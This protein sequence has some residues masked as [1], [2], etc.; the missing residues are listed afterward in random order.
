MKE[1]IVQIAEDDLKVLR[2]NNYLLC[3]AK[4]M[5]DYSYTVVW[6]AEKDFSQN[7]KMTWEDSYSMFASTSRTEGEVVF[8]N[9]LPVQ[10]AQGERVILT[11][12]GTFNGKEQGETTDCLEMRNQYKGIYPGVSVESK[13]FKGETLVTPFFLS[14]E[15]SIPGV[16]KVKPV[17]QI[18]VWFEQKIESGTVIL[19]EYKNQMKYAARSNM[20]EVNLEKEDSVTLLFEDYAW[21]IK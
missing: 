21:K 15:L 9:I 14:P 19:L 6:Q 16:F 1:L 12:Y 18:L 3:V 20:I 4:K 11:S 8:E 2:E 5:E 10:I 13:N 7:N 17:E